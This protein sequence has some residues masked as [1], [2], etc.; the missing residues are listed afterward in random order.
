[1]GERQE[2]MGHDQRPELELTLRLPEGGETDWW[3]WL[4]TLAKST[5]V[6]YLGTPAAV[7]PDETGIDLCFEEAVWEGLGDD[8]HTAVRFRGSVRLRSNADPSSDSDP[9]PFQRV[10]KVLRDPNLPEQ[11]EEGDEQGPEEP[12]YSCPWH[13]RVVEY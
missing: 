11:H 13:H 8:T 7:H 6:L 12:D 2:K 10:G 3:P 9:R 1:M 5:P 4:R